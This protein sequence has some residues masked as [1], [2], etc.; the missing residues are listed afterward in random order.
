L[1]FDDAD[2]SFL[3][4]A[5]EVQ[6][7]FSI[8]SADNSIAITSTAPGNAIVGRATY[9]PSATAASLDTVTVASAATGVCT[10][11]SGV[12]SFVAAGNCTLNFTDPGNSTD[13]AAAQK[14]QTFNVAAVTSGPYSGSSNAD[15]SAS[16]GLCHVTNAASNGSSTSAANGLANCTATTLTLTMNSASPTTHSATV[17]IFSGG[18]WTATALTCSVT[19]GSGLTQ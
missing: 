19:G 3:G 14:L 11:S 13:G 12:V 5:P 4:L 7:T 10:V 17:G 6:Q 18:E 15:P 16:P 8:C 2:N 1:N 9:T